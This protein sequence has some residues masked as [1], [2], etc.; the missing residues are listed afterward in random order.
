MVKYVVVVVVIGMGVVLGVWVQ[1]SVVL[2]GS[3]DVGIVYVNNVGGYVKWVMIQGNMQF[4]WWGLKGKED[5]GGGLFVIFQLENGFYMNNGQF[6]IVNM[7]WN[8]VVFVGLSLECYG[9][10]MF[11]CQMLLMFDYFDLFSM[12]YFVMSWFVFYLGNI[13]GFVVIGNVLYNNLVKYCLLIFVGFLVVVMFVFGNMMNFLIGKLVGVVLNYVNGLF[14]V[15]VVYLNEYDCVI[16]ISQM[17]IILFQGQNIV[18][19]YFVNK[20][21]N[22][23]VGV[24][25]QIGDFFVYGFYMC[26]KMQLNGFFDMFQS[27]DVGVNYCSSVFNMIVGGVVIMMLVGCCWMQVEFGDIYVLLKCMQL[28]VN[29][30]YE[31]GLG[32]VKVVFFMVGVLS[33]VN[34]VIVLIGI[35]YLF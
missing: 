21:E 4:D 9:M 27:Y 29:V 23:G 8:C 33:I 24:L 35:Y 30:F 19:G 17:G 2:Y 22:I 3:M 11:G 10:L 14:K 20:V 1:S 16:L 34:Q 7:I 31:Y 15:L 5:F 25:Y 28:Y 32:G 18:N 12:V 26:V 6:V 13:D